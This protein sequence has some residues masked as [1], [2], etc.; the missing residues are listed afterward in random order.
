MR[1]FL[2][3]VIGP[4]LVAGALVSCG[5]IY[6]LDALGK[7]DGDAAS[8]AG[9]EVDAQPRFCELAT[10]KPTFCSDFDTAEP[11][12]GWDN[13]LLTPDPFVHGGGSFPGAVPSHDGSYAWVA[14]IVA[15]KAPASATLAKNI[16]APTRTTYI[17][18]DVSV[19]GTDPMTPD[20]RVVIANLAVG[21]TPE[22]YV[23]QVSLAY[24]KKNGLYI[25]VSPDNDEPTQGQPVRSPAGRGWM[26]IEMI[27]EQDLKGTDAGSG[28]SIEVY[29]DGTRFVRSGIQKLLATRSDLILM[30][31]ALRALEG[32]DARVLIDNVI[33]DTR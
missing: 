26:R 29:L 4:A 2:A 6:D 19:E 17:A 1:R 32:A 13:L 11:L 25:G 18:F 16:F 9:S 14:E 7:G 24:D 21:A 28:G 27:F 20:E 15:T 3:I 31:G 10:P 33:I 22:V 5:A 30:L 23:G 12:T 8:D